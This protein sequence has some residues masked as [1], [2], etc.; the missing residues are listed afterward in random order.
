MNKENY[1]AH[2]LNQVAERLGV[3]FD[4]IDLLDQAL[5]HASVAC[6]IP[7]PVA[8]YESLE[9]LG[10]A[11]LSLSI[12]HY[13]YSHAPGRG[14]GEYSKMRASVISRT[15]LARI[16]KNLALDEA[17]RLGKGEEQS[18]GR[19]RTALMEDCMEAVIGA[20][21][22]DKGWPETQQF[23]ERAFADEL[24]RALTSADAWD[25]KSRLQHRC[26]SLHGEL[27]EFVLIRSEGPD[28]RKE[29]EIEVRIQ[30]RPMGRGIGTSKKKAE[31]GAARE[32]LQM[33][34]LRVHHK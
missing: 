19:N 2:I 24:K 21:Y 28:H 17:I 11:V 13:L 26:Q 15:C 12:A 29:F 20:L 34:A 14:P 1:R 22:L 33:N 5:T 8:D 31:Q 3:A 18:G 25:Y 4:N 32:A 10:D 6:E 7:G 23:I 30:G 16:A 27:P 9:F